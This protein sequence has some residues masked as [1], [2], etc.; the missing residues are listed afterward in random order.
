MGEML[1]RSAHAPGCGGLICL[2]SFF[3]SGGEGRARCRQA[4]AP[5]FPAPCQHMPCKGG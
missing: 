5:L 1:S 3:Q 2:L 4:E